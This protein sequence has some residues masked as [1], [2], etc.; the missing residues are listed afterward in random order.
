MLTPLI[1]LYLT[2]ASAIVWFWFREE[3]G[4][5]KTYVIM[6]KRIAGALL[7]PLVVVF[8][9]IEAIALIITPQRRE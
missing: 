3:S 7:W 5:E 9:L 8:I 6:A 2:F 4:I 1:V